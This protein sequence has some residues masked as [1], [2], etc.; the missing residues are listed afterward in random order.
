MSTSH[1]VIF[2]ERLRLKKITTIITGGG[3]I[4]YVKSMMYLNKST[5]KSKD[6]PYSIAF[7]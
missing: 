1:I 2:Q 7:L 5:E 4:S 3:I 6:M